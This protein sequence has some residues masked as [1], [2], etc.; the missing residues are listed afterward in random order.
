MLDLNLSEINNSTLLLYLFKMNEN[1]KVIATSLFFPKA[2]IAS[3]LLFPVATIASGKGSEQ[4]AAL[5]T[6][7]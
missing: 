5:I 3:F 2:T 7:G 4:S 1:A 6:Y